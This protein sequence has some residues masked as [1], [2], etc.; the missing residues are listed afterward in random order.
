MLTLSGISKTFGQGTTNEVSALRGIDLQVEPGAFVIVMGNHGAGKSTLLKAITGEQTIDRGDISWDGQDLQCMS[1]T[2]RYSL[3]RQLGRDPKAGSAP[4][5]TLAENFAIASHRDQGWGLHW[6]LH[7]GF[8]KELRDRLQKLSMG[9][10][11]ANRLDEPVGNLSSGQRQALHLL[12]ATWVKP[13]VLLLDDHTADLDSTSAQQVLALTNEVVQRDQI[14]T[15][16]VTHSMP[17]AIAMGHRLIILNRGEVL[18]DISG[19]QKQRLRVED[20]TDLAEDLRR[21]ER[22][23]E[24]AAAMLRAQYV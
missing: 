2:Q 3:L 6:A 9:M 12:M 10:D 18:H 7:S 4:S 11:L 8:K 23:D 13:S 22:I 14:T 17:Q 5:L 24:A 20:L 15:I 16:M 1:P 19:A 21:R